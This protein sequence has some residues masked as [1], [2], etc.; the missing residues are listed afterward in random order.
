[1]LRV[2]ANSST[3]ILLELLTTPSTTSVLAVVSPGAIKDKYKFFFTS[4]Y[5]I[6]LNKSELEPVDLFMLT[7]LSRFLT[8]EYAAC[9]VF[10][11]SAVLASK[12]IVY[13]FIPANVRVPFVTAPPV[14]EADNSNAVSLVTLL[15]VAS[16]GMHL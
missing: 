3:I 4:W 14:V 13:F 16:S 15:T 11:L 10:T 12:S 8:S 6:F 9:F 1:M 2:V 5:I 7:L